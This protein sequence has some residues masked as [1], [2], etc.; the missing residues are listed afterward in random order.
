MS[1]TIKKLNKETGKFWSFKHTKNYKYNMLNKYISINSDSIRTYFFEKSFLLEIKYIKGSKYV[2]PVKYTGTLK[3]GVYLGLGDDK[4]NIRFTDS[5][6][7]RI[8]ES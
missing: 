1:R 5:Q 3:S 6:I 4:S 8:I 2:I 7:L